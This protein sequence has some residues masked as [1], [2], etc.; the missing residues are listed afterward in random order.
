[1]GIPSRK[2]P[3]DIWVLHVNRCMYI[4]AY[5]FECLFILFIQSTGQ[6]IHVA[7]GKCIDA[8]SQKFP[9]LRECSGSD[10]QKWEIE[11]MLRDPPENA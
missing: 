11:R 3:H 6:F 9:E 8:E 2:P 1:M 7:S 4:Y 10:H 5:S